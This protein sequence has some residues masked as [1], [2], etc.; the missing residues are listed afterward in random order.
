MKRRVLSAVALV[1]CIVGS[2]QAQLPPTNIVK[3]Q[4]L[5]KFEE[6]ISLKTLDV[7]NQAQSGTCWSFGITSVLE[8][9]IIS[10]GGDA[11][12]LSDMWIVRH[13][14][15][16][17]VVKYVRLHGN[18]NLSV[19]G[20][21]H[22]VTETIKRYGI[23][24]EIAYT[25]LHYGTKTH[26]FNELDG[27]LKSYA[28]AIIAAGKPTEVW[29]RGL[30]MILDNYF[31]ARIA[32]FEW[33]GKQYTPKTYAK[34]LG[35]NMDNYVSL[36]SFMHHPYG[37]KFMLEVPDNW[38]W[39]SSYN[40]PI[41]ELMSTMDKVLESGHTF[42]LA[43]DI[44]EDGFK[45]FNGV[46]TIPLTEE[47]KQQRWD[48]IQKRR[49]AEFDNYT[50]TDDHCM[51]VVG[52]A[53]NERGEVFY[54]AKNSWGKLEPYGGYIYLSKSFLELKTLLIMVDKELLPNDVKHSFDVK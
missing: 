39:Q 17:K 20:A 19:G 12:N 37:E 53:K 48:Y 35:L 54:K 41:D 10:K 7:E 36:T 40:M 13:A 8:S 22:D 11:V 5:F 43:L 25:G 15:F 47:H 4:E 50:T 52:R 24:P 6:Q 51:Q 14:Y 28:D 32:T 2:I 21:M 3:G 49:Q 42:G 44:T 1:V 30:N 16:D 29:Q 23:V 38:M 27:V 18:L 33:E 31:G 46:A 9:D 34:S 45:T 26:D